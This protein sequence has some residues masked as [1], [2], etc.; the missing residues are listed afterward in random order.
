MRE[1]L[2]ISRRSLPVGVARRTTISATHREAAEKTS[3]I[4]VERLRQKRDR[5]RVYTKPP[6]ETFDAQPARA[7]SNANDKVESAKTSIATA[8][9][10]T[11]TTNHDTSGPH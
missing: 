9:A 8:A 10:T 3:E 11:A 1:N 4:I 5:V 7:N 6:Q 2:P